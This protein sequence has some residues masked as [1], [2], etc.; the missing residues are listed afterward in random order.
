LKA[1]ALYTNG[2]AASTG[3]E[4]IK[5]RLA[6]GYLADFTVLDEDLLRVDP[7][8]L[9]SLGIRST[10]V[11]GKSVRPQ[12]PPALPVGVLISQVRAAGRDRPDRWDRRRPAAGLDMSV[13][14]LV[15]GRLQPAGGHRASRRPSGPFVAAIMRPV[16]AG[17]IGP[18]AREGCGSPFLA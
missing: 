11:A 18:V 14:R 2:A 3:E 1:Q 4:R 15:Y 17:P 9:A 5:G 10:W 13:Y 8:R 16:M 7:R 6:P 12:L